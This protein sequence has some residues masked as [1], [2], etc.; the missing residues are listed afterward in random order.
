MTLLDHKKLLKSL[1]FFPFNFGFVPMHWHPKTFK[2]MYHKNTNTA[3]RA[4]KFL[5]IQRLF[6]LVLLLQ[7]IPCFSLS[8]STIKYTFIDKVAYIFVTCSICAGSSLLNTSVQKASS[9]CFYINGI[10]HLAHYTKNI[11]GLK[12]QRNKSLINK[13]DYGFAALQTPNFIVIP[14]L[15]VYGLHWTSPCK[16]TMIGFFLIPECSNSAEVFSGLWWNFL[17]KCAVYLV[18][19]WSWTAAMCGVLYCISV[20]PALCA[21]SFGDFLQ[22]F[23]QMSISKGEQDVYK[24]GLF[25]RK[26]QV[27]G[28][29][30]NEVQQSDVLFITIVSSLLSLV[31]ALVSTFTIPWVPENAIVLGFFG[32][33]AIEL[34]F[35]LLTVIGTMAETYCEFEKTLN[36]LNGRGMLLD[37]CIKSKESKWKQRFYISC[38]PVKFK[39]G[40]ISFV[41]RLTPLIFM[42]FSV[43]QTVTLLLLGKR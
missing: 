11:L 9:Q 22:G 41:D 6:C 8:S 5:N 19:H 21:L 30:C 25:Y 26:I 12:T 17:V 20:Y 29:L 10:I 15:L 28:C 18:N 13:L 38:T 24:I 3:L 42:L 36:Q 37:K 4:K 35:F 2:L 7:G 39:F 31:T 33:V 23:R 43:D 1:C 32:S 14:I 16:P 34:S 40:Q 27:L